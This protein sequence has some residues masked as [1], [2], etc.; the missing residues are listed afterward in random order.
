MNR[1]RFFAALTCLP[2]V[3][4]LVSDE[5]VARPKFYGALNAGSIDY[6][7]ID[8]EGMEWAPFALNVDAAQRMAWYG[9][10]STTCP[11]ANA[12]VRIS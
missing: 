11:A 6:P 10:I 4:K 5:V 1:R 12:V 2:F 9:P 3:G 7:A 8:W